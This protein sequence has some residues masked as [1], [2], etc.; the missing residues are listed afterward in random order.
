MSPSNLTRPRRSIACG[1]LGAVFALTAIAS[2]SAAD[3]V[4]A[5]DCPALDVTPAAGN[6]DDVRA[7][8]LCLTNAARLRRG[9]QPLRENARLRRAA[10]AHSAD[11]VRGGYFAHT[12]PDGETFVDR[13]VDAGY[14]RQYDGWTL[15]E[16]LAWGTGSVGTARALHEALMRSSGHRANILKAAYRELGIGVRA[17]VPANAGVGVTLTTTFGV[18]A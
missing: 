3:R 18:T 17:G 1:L 13:I 14:T 8:I 2:A 5:A 4:V 12:T 9:V 10:V 16:N 11:M 6:T 15:G 7:A